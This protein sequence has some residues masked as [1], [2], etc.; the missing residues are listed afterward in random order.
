M[1]IEKGINDFQMIPWVHIPGDLIDEIENKLKEWC[2]N[3]SIYFSREEMDKGINVPM[4]E[5]QEEVL[6]WHEMVSLGL[7]GALNLTVLLG[8]NAQISVDWVK[9][10]SP[11]ILVCQQPLTVAPEHRNNIIMKLNQ[12]GYKIPGVN[13]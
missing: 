6:S 11:G 13:L 4:V 7:L 1:Q 8:R 10:T 12:Y 2:A 3:S 5:G 9:G